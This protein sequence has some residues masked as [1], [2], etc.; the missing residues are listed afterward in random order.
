MREIVTA[1]EMRAW[2]DQARGAG[3]RIGLVPTMGYLHDGH[4]SLVAEARRRAE[5]CVASIFVN[6]LQ[7]GPREDLDRYPRDLRRDRDALRA[8]GVEVLYLPTADEMYPPGFQTA[9]SVAKVSAGLCG[10]SRPGHFG[11]V[12]TVVTKLFNAVKPHVAVFGEKDFQQL[13]V[14]RRMAND[15]DTG[16]EV[17]G[18]PIVR[19]ADGVAMSSRNAY[20]SDAERTAARCLSRALAAAREAVA[21]GARL[22]A[23]VL[24]AARAVLD[25][26]PAARV[27]YVALV[28]VDSLE[29]VDPITERALLALAVFIGRTRLIDN[30]I[31]TA[32]NA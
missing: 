10:R 19:E 4:L 27:D 32:S 12:T 23:D 21:G 14:I 29:P 15:L 31:L 28:D 11:G 24:A 30:T 20:L 2:A 13:A 9:V 18:A 1:A 25:A 8:A 7:F 17:V 22:A 3:R 16:I 5:A 6:P 26:E